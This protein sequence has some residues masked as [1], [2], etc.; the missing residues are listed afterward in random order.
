MSYKLF[1]DDYRTPEMVTWAKLA[2]GPWVIVKDYDEF[3]AAIEE[4]GI[5][6]F[7]AYD[8]DLADIHHD[9]T[10]GAQERTGWHCAAFLIQEYCLE[11]EIPHPPYM[12]H[13]MNPVGAERIRNYIEDYNRVWREDHPNQ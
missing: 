3:R 1:L 6:E 9:E 8:H 11:F 7:I 10:F 2:P 12:V 5:P 4:H 13:S